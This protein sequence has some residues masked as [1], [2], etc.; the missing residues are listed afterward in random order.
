MSRPFFIKTVIAAT[1]LLGVLL[2][3]SVACGDD[4]GG[5]GGGGASGDLQDIADERGLT[6]EDMKH[7]LQ[8]YVPPGEYDPYVMIASG[9]HS[10]Q[11][12]VIGVPS[13]RILKVIGVFTPEPWQGYGERPDGDGGPA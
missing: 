5:G 13:M 12:L 8:A 6:P 7:A 2:M 9:G 1:A 11:L 10:G 3:L 4:D